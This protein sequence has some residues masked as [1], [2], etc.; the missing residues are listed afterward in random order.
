VN[1]LERI[2]C[3][4][5][6]PALLLAAGHL[7]SGEIPFA[8]P[9]EIGLS[10]ETLD[11]IHPTMQKFV[12]EGD[13]PGAVTLIARHGRI[14]YFDAVGMRDCER[15]LP[16]TKD[17][18]FRIHSMTKPIT[19]VALMTLYDEGRFK[20]DDPLSLYLSEFA[21]QKV[22]TPEGEVPVKRDLTIRDLMTHSGGLTY[23]FFGDTPVDQL[24]READVMNRDLTLE[25]M[26]RKIGSLPLAFHPG[27]RWLY[28]VS[29]DVQGRMIEVLSGLSFDQ[30]LKQRIL[31]PLDM[32][33][34]DFYVPESKVDRFAANYR[35]NAAGGITLQD[36][37]R[38]SLYLTNP[39][40][41]SGGGGL[42]STA[43]DYLRFAQM[44]LNGGEL[45]GR[46]ILRSSTVDLMRKNQLPEDVWVEWDGTVMTGTGF[47]LDFAVRTE[48]EPA[49]R[50][51]QYWWVGVATTRF[52]V[53]PESDLVVISMTQRV[54]D[55]GILSDPIHRILV[56]AIQP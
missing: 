53:W 31:D 56:E 10:A 11:K 9:T 8:A 18:I 23:G 19:G 28:S 29:V 3:R 6:A 25:E 45:E 49:A 7:V 51:N 21:D 27:E 26:S 50:A 43:R 15:Q 35:V 32:R 16:M 17:T 39:T 4:G 52:F 37:P 1:P 46:R 14:A 40:L 55:S 13:I 22:H 20:L 47:G 34:T 5:V 42:V 24:Y 48:R 38:T 30:F 44:L 2:L 12:D 41:K 54:M 33:D 36:D